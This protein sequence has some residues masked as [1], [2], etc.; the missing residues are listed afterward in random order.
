MKLDRVAR[1]EAGLGIFH[2]TL[3]GVLSKGSSELCPQGN[4]F[5]PE[6][7]IYEW[8]RKKS[9]SAKPPREYPARQPGSA[10]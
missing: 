8:L 6:Q 4:P 2:F 5:F 9:R 1:L 10:P 3:A 7:L